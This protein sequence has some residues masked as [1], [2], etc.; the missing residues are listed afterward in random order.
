MKVM[1]SNN[2]LTVTVGHNVGDVPVHT[3]TTVVEEMFCCLGMGG[4][5]AWD[6][7]GCYV[8]D[9]GKRVYETSTRVEIGYL[10][11]SELSR[12]LGA[13]RTL[14]ENLEQE[15]LFVSVNNGVPFGVRP[16][17]EEIEVTA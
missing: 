16:D 7:N 3:Q 9:S 14:C 1:K 13:L 6:L 17:S 8:H 10:P 4:Y 12:M 11:A 2:L 5:S 15:E